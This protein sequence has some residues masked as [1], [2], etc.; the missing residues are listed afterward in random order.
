M[1]IKNLRGFSVFNTAK[2]TVL[3]KRFCRFLQDNRGQTAPVSS[4][5]F[6]QN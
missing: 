2:N 3:L 6:A 4:L 5:P 1:K